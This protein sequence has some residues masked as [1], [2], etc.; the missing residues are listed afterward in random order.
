MYTCIHFCWAQPLPA[1][2]QPNLG[3]E[4]RVPPIPGS[5]KARLGKEQPPAQESQKSWE[6]R[7]VPHCPG[8][9]PEHHPQA[10]A[11]KRGTNL[12]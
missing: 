12:H 4:L 2:V 9:C 3:R 1:D 10:K 11:C 5:V 8:K 7:D 6:K